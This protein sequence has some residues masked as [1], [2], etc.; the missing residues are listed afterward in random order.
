MIYNPPTELAGISADQ[1]AE[2]RAGLGL[3]VHGAAPSPIKTWGQGGIPEILEEA[4]KKLGFQT[5]LPLQAQLVPAL[6]SELKCLIIPSTGSGTALATVAMLYRPVWSAPVGIR[7]GRKG[8]IGL[9]AHH[10][11]P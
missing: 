8:P 11:H 9:L 7:Q 1:L 4:F 10:R 3:R 5:P 6:L 2:L